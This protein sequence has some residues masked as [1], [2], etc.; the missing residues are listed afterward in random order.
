[1]DKLIAS[2]II[3]ELE[4][5]GGPL[6]YDDFEIYA[7]YPRA[8]FRQTLNQLVSQGTLE[9][10]GSQYWLTHEGTR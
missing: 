10:N 5:R 4:E 6:H 9:T 8:D 2:E 1:M 7:D 3:R